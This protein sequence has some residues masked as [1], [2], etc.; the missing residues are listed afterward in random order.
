MGVL[1]IVMAM[2]EA[3]DA[4]SVVGNHDDKLLRWLRGRQ[5]RITHGLDAS[6]RAMEA[7]PDGTRR[8]VEAFLASL[9]S[10]LVLDDGGLVVAHA[11]LAE[12]YH[13]ISSPK[14]R[15]LAM[16]GPTQ[17][18][19]D[20]WGFPLRIDWAADYRGRAAVVYGHTPVIEA[21]WRN[22]TIDI[23]TGAVF[24]HRLTAVRYPERDI[25]WVPA[26]RVY[27]PKGGP[28]RRVGPGGPPVE[29][30]LRTAS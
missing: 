8:A 23:D 7:A 15:A 30:P 18:G 29:M 13:G 22:D 2:A 16:F 19:Q 25:V 12:R 4:S 11:G 14:V 5:V 6:I 17:P 20:R 3:G 27:Y 21:V 1:G 26:E 9:P 10:H 28:F 24:G